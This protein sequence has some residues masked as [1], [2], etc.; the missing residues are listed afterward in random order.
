MAHDIH[1]Q[2]DYQKI[3]QESVKDPE[4]FW[5]EV[6]GSLSW[7]KSWDKVLEWDFKKPDVKWFIGGKLNITENCIDRHLPAK[8]NQ[9]AILWEPNDPSHETRHITYQELHDEVCKVGNMLR[10]HGIGKGDRVC[11]YM[12]MVPEAAFAI[13]GCARIGAVHSVVFAGFSAGSLVDRINDSGC[14]AV[15]TSDGAFRGDKKID[16][17]KIVDEALENCPTVESVF[18]LE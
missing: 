11:I 7:K 17:K 3:Y 1:S 4:T 14:K 16:L 8:A 12:P 15:L 2:S 13:L 18:V 5:A 10:A 9:T 6:A